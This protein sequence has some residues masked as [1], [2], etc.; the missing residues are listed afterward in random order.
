MAEAEDVAGECTGV[1][2]VHESIECRRMLRL[3]DGEQGKQGKQGK[4]EGRGR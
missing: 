4:S 2:E 3:T 1:S